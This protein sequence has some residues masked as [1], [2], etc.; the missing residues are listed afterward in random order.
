LTDL[1]QDVKPT[2]L[3]AEL[4]IDVENQ[5][6]VDTDDV[7]QVYIKCKDSEFAV[8]N[9][10]LCAFKRIHVEKNGKK[11]ISLEIKADAF[12]NVNEKGKR[13]LDGKDYVLYVGFSQPDAVS[14]ALTGHQP[15]EIPVKIEALTK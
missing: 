2:D 4:S 11:T 13:V 15:F 10:K 9:H 5:K 7:L 14:V 3:A 12:M 6:A 8:R 1:K